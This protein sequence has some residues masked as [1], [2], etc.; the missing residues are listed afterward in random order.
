[1]PSKNAPKGA[2]FLQVSIV[3]LGRQ[4]AYI[5]DDQPGEQPTYHYP[6]PDVGRIVTVVNT[7]RRAALKD[8]ILWGLSE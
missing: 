5:A 3:A 1:M 6:P 7:D 8:I 4:L 2:M